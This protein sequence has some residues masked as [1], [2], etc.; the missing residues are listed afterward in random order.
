[1]QRRAVAVFTAFFVIVGALSFG[2]VVT[3]ESPHLDADGQELQAGDSV[4]VSGQEYTVDSVDVS[5][6]EGDGHGGGGDTT[7]E[8]VFEWT[9][10]DAQYTESWAKNDTVEFDNETWRVLVAE[11]DD[12]ASFTLEQVLDK[13][14]ILADDPDA[15]NETVMYEDEAH[16]VIEEDG[17]QTLVPADEY[18]PEPETREYSESETIDYN[19]NETTIDTVTTDAVELNWTA[20]ETMSTSAGQRGNVTLGDQTFFVEFL[21]ESTIL[22]SDDFEALNQHNEATQTYTYHKNGLWGVTLLSGAT[23]VLLL[24]MAYMP[25]RY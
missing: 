6:S 11:G 15:D 17:E 13:E 24:G 7:Y 8:A 2:L 18:F 22:L 5:E 23:A 20:P 16:V 12:P 21:D 9:N 19:G 1:M 14:T 10:P 3:A 4:T 25:S